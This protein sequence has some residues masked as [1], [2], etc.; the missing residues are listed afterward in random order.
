MLV[1][2]IIA[3]LAAIAVPLF[4]SEARSSKSEAET[5][6]MF[7]ALTLA[8]ES[9]KLENGSYLATGSSEGDTWPAIPSP[10]P[11]PLQPYPATWTTLKV[12]PPADSARCGYVV[13]AGNGGEAAG[14][15]AAA[16]FAFT[17]PTSAPWY[18][19]L[20]HCDADNDTTVDG[21]FFESS[22]DKTIREINA[23]N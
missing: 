3:V 21:Y 16:N 13:L 6:A 1:V 8:E 15:I 11:Q 4:T 10:T 12:T 20:A 22:V 9:Y 2:V 17:P 23:D 7:T 19:V 18:Y 5:A 14:P